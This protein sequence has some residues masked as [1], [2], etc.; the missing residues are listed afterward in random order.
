[1]AFRS[2]VADGHGAQ[3]LSAHHVTVQDAGGRFYRINVE[4]GSG[5]PYRRL[6]RG[7]STVSRASPSRHPTLS[8]AR[9]ALANGECRY[10]GCEGRRREDGLNEV[11]KQRRIL[12]M[13]KQPGGVSR[14]AR[15]QLCLWSPK[16]LADVIA[17]VAER[18]RTMQAVEEEREE[19]GW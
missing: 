6:A 8:R 16:A 4:P 10:L 12:H 17:A 9:L 11:R 1:M 13:Y 18:G 5:E 19:F 15:R 2:T 14:V 3:W 7:G